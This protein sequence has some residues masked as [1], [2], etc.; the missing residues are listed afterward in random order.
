MSLER[1]RPLAFLILALPLGLF[2]TAAPVEG[3]G[4]GTWRDCNLNCIEDVI[5]IAQGTSLD[6]DQN[7]VPDECEPT[8]VT[9]CEGDGA[10]N[11][12][13]DCPCLNNAPQGTTEGCLNRAGVGAALTGTGLPS[14]SNDTLHLTCTGMPAGVPGYFFQGQAEAGF[15]NYGNGL[16]CIGGPF[17][18]MKK[19]AGIPGGVT[20]P[21]RGD[22]PIS[23]QLAIPAGATRYYQV[24]YRDN[25]GP[26]SNG[27]NSSN[28]V[29][30][31]WG[32]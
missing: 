28:G 14:V 13:T 8:I 31:V 4:G 21:L 11:G 5:D 30:V 20:L 24:L 25:L 16:R 29:K 22:P 26:C 6:L 7:G 19:I 32:L 17:I 15:N 3:D 9:W 1:L 18:R 2:A 10:L 12:G 27:T 23:Q